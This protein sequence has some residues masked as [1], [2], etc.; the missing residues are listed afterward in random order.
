MRNDEVLMAVGGFVAGAGLVYLLDPRSGARRR[1]DVL[2]EAAHAASEIGD[3]AGKA[4]RDLLN[5]GKGLFASL[6]RLREHEV[7]D[8][9]LAERVRAKLGRHT[10]HPGAIE[11]SVE[12]GRV[13]LKGD[14]L[15]A[16]AEGVLDAIGRV[17]GVR[18]ID[19]DLR[20]CKTAEGVPSL[21]GGTGRPPGE[22]VELLQ[23][24]WA[25]GTRVV[26]GGAGLALLIGGASR[27]GIAGR[28]LSV[29]GGLLLARAVS[30]LELKRL[31][32]VGG[33]RRAVDV[34]K[35]IHIAAAPEEVYA[36]FAAMENLPR[37]MD[38]VREV[39]RTADGLYRWRVAGPIGVP[40]EWTAEVT[41]Q[42]PNEV[43]AWKTVPGSVVR[44]AGM[45]R[46]TPEGDG[47]RLDVRLSYN[48]P[49]GAL[50]HA[51]AHLLGSDPKQQMDDDLLRLKSLLEE[52]KATG[53]QGTVRREDVQPH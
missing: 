7:D 42:V 26:A 13:E 8:V 27:G 47:T 31:F 20:R 30:N 17:R 37:F 11:V 53:H 5:R 43:L 51:V 36:Y 49:A 24:N 40:V 23:A 12:N 3:T 10:S 15:I 33:G 38:H 22:A 34:R 16:E 29:A 21:Q 19:D 25:P 50:G 45:V 41:E 39:Q 28:A 52:G 9:V 14:V 35:A 46:F 32:G 6:R 48:P 18:E 1:A 44:S 4:S 2:H